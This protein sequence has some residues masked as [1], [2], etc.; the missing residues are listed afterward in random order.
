M[1]RIYHQDGII[2]VK[3]EIFVF[4]SNE[5]GIHGTGAAKVARQVFGAKTG[6]GRGRTGNAYAI[7]TKGKN[8]LGIPVHEVKR[9][10]EHF[11]KYARATPN[12]TFFITR[13][14]CGT[15]GN[16]DFEI[17]PFFIDAPE[18]C[19]MPDTWKAFLG[20]KEEEIVKI[21]DL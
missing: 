12:L 21:I 11:L 9:E 19:I 3:G 14:G 18:N 5:M 16:S 1:N 7:P 10:V 15:A 17:A 8:L 2:P 4:G 13:V 20:N 6:T